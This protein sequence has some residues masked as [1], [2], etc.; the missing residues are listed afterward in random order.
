MCLLA[1]G[2]CPHPSLLL[3]PKR[4]DTLTLIC[5]SGASKPQPRQLRVQMAR[6]EVGPRMQRTQVCANMR[7]QGRQAPTPPGG[8]QVGW[9]V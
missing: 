6:W 5:I 7:V 4:T 9:V 2:A 8:G 3:Q 1:G